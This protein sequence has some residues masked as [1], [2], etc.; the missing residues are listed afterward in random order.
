VIEGRLAAVDQRTLRSYIVD[1]LSVSRHSL[2]HAL[3][4]S[5]PVREAATT[6]YDSLLEAAADGIGR[7]FAVLPYE[8]ARATGRWL[9]KLHG[10]V[11]RPEDIVITRQD[12]IR[13]D[14]RRSALAG[15]LQ[16]LL[17]TRE[18]LF[19]GF[20]LTDDNFI[21]VAD[22]V[23]KALSGAAASAERFGTAVFLGSDEL[24]QMI[25]GDEVEFLSVGDARLVD[26]FLDCVLHHSSLGAGHL[27]DPT[28]VGM[29][30]TPERRLA[31]LLRGLDRD[32]S[33]EVRQLPAWELVDDVLGR[34]GRGDG[35]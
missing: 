28:F 15:I 2:A 17:I 4:A 26:V 24:M 30:S 31:E 25:W 9:L 1:R 13:Y 6:N 23:R 29:L 7:P 8:N 35:A 5:L 27:L 3:L 16:A 34:F 12:Y 20:S 22:S 32:A 33:T 19:V 11:D 21:R 18:M 14:D 10:S